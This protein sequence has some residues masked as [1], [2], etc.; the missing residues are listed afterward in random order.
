MTK[1]RSKA[2]ELGD[3]PSKTL[4]CGGSAGAFLSAQV[5]YH[6][7]SKG[8]NTS[9][10]GLALLFAVGLHW[11]YEGRYKHLYT[12][13]EENG[14]SGT[15][16]FGRELAEFIW[17]KPTC[18]P[19][20][21]QYLTHSAHYDVDF[22]S[23]RHFPLLADDLSRFP[24]SYIVTAEKDCF[25]DD[26]TVLDHRLKESGVRCRLDYYQGLPHYFHA[27]PALDVAHEM[28]AKAVEGVRYILG[29]EP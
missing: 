4:L 14:Y 15:P 8:D 3:D 23:P 28:M 16:V 26:G 22:E 1:A 17:C 27:F 7:M 21:A 24:P 9:V 10:T 18:N 5:A 29:E 6:F 2:K 13:W 19:S 11:K 20:L 12:A 25:R